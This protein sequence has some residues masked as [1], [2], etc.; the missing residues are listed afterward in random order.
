M[1]ENQR[2]DPQHQPVAARTRRLSNT[3]NDRSD[4]PCKQMKAARRQVP[5]EKVSDQ[6]IRDVMLEKI[7]CILKKEVASR[8]EEEVKLLTEWSFL[9]PTADAKIRHELTKSVLRQREIEQEES[10]ESIELK[11]DALAQLIEDSNYIV[12]YT[13]AGISTSASIPDYRGPNGLWTQFK[14]TGKF[15]VNKEHNF[16]SA[17]P[18]LTHMAIRE[19]C[20]RKIVNH[21]VS[22]NCDG[23][24]L[25]SGIP[26]SHLSEIHGNMYI[27]VC[28]N[29][30]KQYYRQADTTDR[31]ARFRH[32]TGRKCHTCPEPNNKLID[33]I[34]LYGERSRTQWPMNWSRAGKAAKRADLII[35]MGSSLKTLRRYNDL[36]PKGISRSGNKE[37]ETKL[38]II[39][40]QYTPKDQNAVLKINGKCDLVMQL[41][42]QRL[43]ID[44]PA[45]ECI[46]DALHH[47]AIPFTADEQADLKRNLIF[48]TRPVKFSS[49]SPSSSLIKGNLCDETKSS[50]T[51]VAELTD[52]PERKRLKMRI[53]AINS[54]DPTSNAKDSTT[55][56][57]GLEV[58]VTY[59]EETADP[60]EA[61]ESIQHIAKPLDYVLPGWIAKSIGRPRTKGYKRKRHG[62]KGKKHSSVLKPHNESR[63]THMSDK[64]P[65]LNDD[66]TVKAE[67]IS[68]ETAE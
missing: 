25:R 58:G 32:Q 33:T 50:G 12:I 66:P 5:C 28:P 4:G 10:L 49:S 59:V 3:S 64:V 23:L 20:R 48:D 38:V 52:D 13:G 51:F 62:N 29:C 22:Q 24:H 41:V 16:A 27:E 30:E 56:Q 57:G 54:S 46:N 1:S 47:L 34:V 18:T 2:L 45:Y 43:N 31:T 42:M 17:E 36:W 39:N 21:V 55:D 65:K 11:A 37:P 8:S 68:P 63:N 14:K 44:V 35:C 15:L 60:E 53:R 7:V 6:L 40:L 61:T 67:V 19:L 9:K 26:Q